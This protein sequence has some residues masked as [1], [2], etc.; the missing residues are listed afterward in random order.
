MIRFRNPS[1]SLETMLAGFEQLYNELKDKAHFDN[2]DIAVALAKANLMASSGFTGDAGRLLGANKNKS[3]DKTYNNAKMF[4]EIYRLLGLI[5]VVNHVS[6][7]Y[8]FTYIGEHMVAPGA[9][10]KAIIEQ[11]VL[12]VNNPNQIIDVSY[13]ESVR[14]FS[15]VLLTMNR[16]DGMICRDEMILG[17][18]NVNDNSPAEFDKMI[19]YIKGI[20]GN[21]EQLQG[22]LENLAKSLQDNKKEG[23]AVESMQNCTRFPIS[24]LKYCDWAESV[25]T[26]IYGKSIRFMQLTKHGYDTVNRLKRMQ[27]IRLVDYEKSTNSQKQ[28]MIRLGVYQMLARAN[29]NLAPVENELRKDEKELQDI[30]K[31]K[32]ILFSPYQTLEL[33]VVNKALNIILEKDCNG[34]TGKKRTHVAKIFAKAMSGNLQKV[35]I[36]KAVHLKE[37]F[38]TDDVIAFVEHIH[39]LYKKEKNI[40][41]LTKQMVEEHIADKKAEFYPLVETLFRIIGVDCHK[42][43]DGVNGERWDGMIRDPQKSIP[44]EIKSPTEELYL[45]IKAIR[46]ALE[47]KII[48]L[49][50]GTYKTDITCSSYAVG[51]YLPNNRAEVSELIRNIKDTYG[52]RIAVFGIESLIHVAINIVLFGKGI[53]TSR[54]YGLEGIINVEDIKC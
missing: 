26:K 18:M 17:P 9:N 33:S 15:C 6:S 54:L 41:K 37:D 27:D 36:D 34:A 23:M 30:L 14:F 28:A 24:V 19:Q 43:R 31:G 48:L 52:Y 3:R 29:F 47:N 42:S 5:S 46:Q 21:Y 35:T 1:S 12:G 11:C 50:R 25:N 13:K 49:S 45:S 4:A 8:R 20:R 32:E 38:I 2:D 16:L 39:E 7:N 53:D 51:F 44:I 40:Q 22:E 10:K